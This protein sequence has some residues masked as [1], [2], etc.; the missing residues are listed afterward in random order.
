MFKNSTAL[1]VNYLI[2]NNITVATAE[3]CTAGMVASAIGDIPRVS[4]IFNEGFITY[5][6]EAKE[7]HL[8]VPHELLEKHG[9]VSHEVCAAMAE[10]V[11]KATGAMLGISTTG[12]AGPGGGTKDKPV[13]L[14]YI[15]ICYNGKTKVFKYIFTGDR[16]NVRYKTMKYIF[17]EL[18]KILI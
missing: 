1:V 11:C 10:G 16:K 8:G 15:G 7:K 3:S 13:G 5:S 14:V 12:I 4:S 17:H 2:E 9:A 18:K 6:N